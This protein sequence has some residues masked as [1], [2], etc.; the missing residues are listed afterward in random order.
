MY[1]KFL[2]M[3]KE[4]KQGFTILKTKWS[5]RESM[6]ELIKISAMRALP[7]SMLRRLREY[8]LI[9]WRARNDN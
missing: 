9:N 5:V 8:D 2:K 6:S 7:I 4:V 3:I 1:P